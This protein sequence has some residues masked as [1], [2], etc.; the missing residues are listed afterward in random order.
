MR[1]LSLLV[2]VLYFLTTSTLVTG[3][4]SVYTQKRA[5]IRRCRQVQECFDK[6]LLSNSDNLYVLGKAFRS[7]QPRPGIAVIINYYIMYTVQQNNFAI[8]PPTKDTTDKEYDDDYMNT[9]ELGE[10]SNVSTVKSTQIP[11]SRQTFYVQQIGWSSSGVYTQIRPAVLLAFQP[12]W[13]LWTLSFGIN[14]YGYPKTINL[15]L[16][17]SECDLPDYRDAKEALEYLTAKVSG[18]YS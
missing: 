5:K 8:I 6:S 12:A 13:L 14:N 9:T 2:P 11:A 1:L 4:C 16:N 18:D 15:Y 7:T 10:Y 3:D 17:I